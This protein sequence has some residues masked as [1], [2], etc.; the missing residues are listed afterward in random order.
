M[1]AALLDEGLAVHCVERVFEVDLE[2]DFV[3][4]PSVAHE[5]LPGCVKRGFATEGLGNT[6]LQWPEQSLGLLLIGSAEDF[7]NQ[8]AERF[9]YRHGADPAVF[10]RKSDQTGAGDELGEMCGGGTL[11][12]QNND[13]GDVLEDFVAVLGLEGGLE[14]KERK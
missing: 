5:P 11:G 10:F 7:G 9:A 1:V 14:G 4:V 6:D 12:K 8:P 13:T 2:E 3:A